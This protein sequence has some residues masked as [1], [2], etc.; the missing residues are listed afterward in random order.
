MIHVLDAERGETEGRCESR[1]RRPKEAI[2]A[3]NRELA[4]AALEVFRQRKDGRL[5]IWDIAVPLLARGVY[6]S[7]IPPDSLRGVLESDPRF[8]FS[9]PG[10]LLRELD[11]GIS[12]MVE[13]R[14]DPTRGTPVIDPGV[15]YQLKVTLVG[16]RPPIWRRLL[17]PANTPLSTLH[18]LLQIAM[19]WTDTHLHQFVLGR[20]FIG[21]PDPDNWTEVEDERKLRLSDLARREKDRFRYEYDFGDSWEHDI[22]LEKVLPSGANVAVASCVAG[23]GAC[24]PEDVGGVWGYE[25]F[26]EAL[27]DPTHK[28][29]AWLSEWF[30]GEFDANAFDLEGVNAELRRVR[31]R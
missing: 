19:G 11:L 20:R 7:D 22:V 15:V 10:G 8:T 2:A 1:S 9:K 14:I 16:F 6:Q 17:V 23:R 3:R 27:Q 25:R 12:T 21:V 28:E 31:I 5:A 4:D 30:G 24:P 26:L 29:H 18:G 13:L